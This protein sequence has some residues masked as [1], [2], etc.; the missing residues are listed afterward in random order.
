MWSREMNAMYGPL[1]KWNIVMNCNQFCC[2]SG[3][4]WPTL[5]FA[6]FEQTISIESTR[7]SIPNKNEC[8]V[9][10]FHCKFNS[11]EYLLVSLVIHSSLNVTLHTQ[12]FPSTLVVTALPFPAALESRRISNASH[13]PEHNKPR[14][15]KNCSEKWN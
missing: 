3:F 12:F 5:S 8:T 11:F 4:Y 10:G 13:N 9:A 6:Q 7:Y 2:C 15:K 1:Q 14:R